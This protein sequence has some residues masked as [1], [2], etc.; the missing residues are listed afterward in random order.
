V[1]GP[2]ISLLVAVLLI[3]FVSSTTQRDS[4]SSKASIVRT[5]LS[6]ARTMVMIS[7]TPK[8]AFCETSTSFLSPV[9]HGIR[10]EVVPRK[11]RLSSPTK[12]P[13]SSSRSALMEA[14]RHDLEFVLVA[15]DAAFGTSSS[16]G[17]MKVRRPLQ[18][19]PSTG[20]WKKIG[21]KEAL[22]PSTA[23]FVTR[24]SLK[25]PSFTEDMMHHHHYCENTPPPHHH[26]RLHTKASQVVPATRPSTSSYYPTD[27]DGEAPTT[28]FNLSSR[29]HGE[30]SISTTNKR[31]HHDKLE[32]LLLPFLPP[33]W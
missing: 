15:P 6:P 11:L 2:R 27:V 1:S 10:S 24:R 5:H 9:T 4:I 21:F 28:H 22:R 20:F 13:Q 26:Y 30:T 23:Y 16:K 8:S 32:T 33:D 17:R 19:R 29:R 18:P 25:F 14:R 12:N 31:N 7:S 3:F